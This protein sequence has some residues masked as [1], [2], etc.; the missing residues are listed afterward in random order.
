MGAEMDSVKIQDDVNRLVEKRLGKISEL[1]RL[2]ADKAS[3]VADIKSVK[4]EFD[5]IDKLLQDKMD[6]LNEHRK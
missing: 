2:N 4:Q 6:L 3:M 5:S 1:R